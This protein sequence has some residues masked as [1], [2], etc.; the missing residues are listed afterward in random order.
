MR[1]KAGEHAYR[2]DWR[3]TALN[4]LLISPDDEPLRIPDEVGRGLRREAGHRSGVK[5]ATLSDGK[6]FSRLWR[7]HGAPAGR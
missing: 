3:S 5:A 4:G 7:A 2:R 6:E 1:G